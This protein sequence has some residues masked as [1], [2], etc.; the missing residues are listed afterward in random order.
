MEPWWGDI[1]REVLRW[2]ERRGE[3]SVTELAEHL[4]LSG[5]ATS[6]LLA[7]LAPAGVV[8][9]ARVAPANDRAGAA[10]E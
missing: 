10:A 1:D 8:R 2:L 5:S 7:V 9:I 6:P 4:A 3:M